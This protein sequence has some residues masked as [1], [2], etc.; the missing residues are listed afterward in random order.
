MRL[1]LAPWRWAND[2]ALRVQIWFIIKQW[3]ME[4]EA[5]AKAEEEV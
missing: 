4:D 1:L 3:Q 5:A 2:I